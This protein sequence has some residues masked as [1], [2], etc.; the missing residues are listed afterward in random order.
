MI[1]L[2]DDPARGRAL[3]VRASAHVR[4]HFS[5]RA[6]GLRYAARIDEV[7]RGAASGGGA[8]PRAGRLSA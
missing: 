8:A 6:A 1:A 7:L 5:L 3:G 2:V 4:T